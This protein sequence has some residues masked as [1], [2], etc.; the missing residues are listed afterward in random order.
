[1]PRA[2]HESR[3]VRGYIDKKADNLKSS[4]VSDAA[5]NVTK[6]LKKSKSEFRFEGNKEQFKFNEE[7]IDILSD[8][9]SSGD[10]VSLSKGIERALKN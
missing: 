3:L 10:R 9:L 1:M 4:V 2:K 8:S 5:E 7:V 6:R